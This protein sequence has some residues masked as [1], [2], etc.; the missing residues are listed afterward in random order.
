MNSQTNGILRASEEEKGPLVEK[1]LDA[2]T[3]EVE[4]LLQDAKP[5]F[6]GSEKLTL[7]EVSATFPY[8]NPSITFQ[9]IGWKSELNALIDITII[10]SKQDLSSFVFWLI[11]K[12]DWLRRVF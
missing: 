5:F 11:R 2:V 12:V 9:M 7:A 3:K 4:P 1:L 10:R 6:G 8:S